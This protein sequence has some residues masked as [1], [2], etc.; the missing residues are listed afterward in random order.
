MERAAFAQGAGR[1]TYLVTQGWRLVAVTGSSN[2]WFIV[3]EC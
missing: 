2:Y 3:V 1:A